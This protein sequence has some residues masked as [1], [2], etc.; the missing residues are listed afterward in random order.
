[1]MRSVS[2][3]IADLRRTEPCLITRVDESTTKDGVP[4]WV[5]SFSDGRQG[6]TVKRDLAQE[7]Y[8]LKG[9]QLPVI[10]ERSKMG[11]GWALT[12]IG[13]AGVL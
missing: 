1:M 9:L 10:M 11:Y 12:K 7:C 5:I 3:L 13:P 2:D 8:R 6:S 4:R